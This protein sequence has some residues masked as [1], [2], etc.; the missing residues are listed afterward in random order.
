MNKDMSPITIVMLCF[1]MLG[2]I[3]LIFGNKLGLG[4]EFERGILL[5]GVMG[6]SMIGMIVL[7]PTIAEL[8]GPAINWICAILPIEPSVI[9]S[10]LLAND[11]GG[12]PLAM[13]FATNENVGYYNGLIV[14]AMMGATISFT[15]PFALGVVPK[16]KH[17]SL[18]LGLL[19]GIA[20]TPIGCFVSGLICRLPAKDLL[21]SLIPLFL[22]AGIVATGLFLA[23]NA[24]LKVFKVF[25]GFI[26]ALIIAG[27]ALGIF[28][29]LTG[30]ELIPSAAPISEGFDICANAAMVLSGAFPLVYA[31]SKILKKPMQ[32]MGEKLGINPTSAVGLLSMLATNAAALGNM[33]DMDEKGAMLNAAFAVSPAF[34]FGGHLAFTM[35]FNGEYVVSMIIGKLIAGVAALF[36]AL[37]LYKVMNKKKAA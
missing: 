15:L 24:C 9:P 3:D 30:T 32:W 1:S 18:M 8:I 23:P 35:S 22:F 13:E 34:V 12:A 27:L 14:A 10:M 20:T 25:G 6:T 26:K 2:A 5:L 21:A 11:M 17:D 36:V 4:K 29:A 33:K 31:L 7:A 16:E 37:L 19:C 28:E